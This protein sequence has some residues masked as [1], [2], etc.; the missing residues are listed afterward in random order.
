VKY[1]NTLLGLS[2]NLWLFNRN[3]AD[4]LL[5]TWP[6]LLLFLRL[7][8]L[9]DRN[10]LGFLW[11]DLDLLLLGVQH[12]DLRLSKKKLD[13]ATINVTLH[14]FSLRVIMD[15]R[16]SVHVSQFVCQLMAHLAFFEQKL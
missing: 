11:N 13:L 12:E 3:F 10:R 9:L 4:R 14:F 16:L 8:G 5:I 15:G 2:L 7:L 6:N 1:F